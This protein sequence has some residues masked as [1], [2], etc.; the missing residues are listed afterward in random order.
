MKIW[1]RINLTRQKKQMRSKE[2]SNISLKKK[3]KNKIKKTIKC[4]ELLHTFQ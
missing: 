4:Q 3:E 2:E 1:E